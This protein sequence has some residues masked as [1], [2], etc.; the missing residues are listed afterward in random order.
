MYYNILD[1]TRR[2]I[3][4]LFQELKSHFYLAG[5]TAL[6]L[7]IGH[8]DSYDFDF[9]TENDIDTKKLFT[10][11]EVICKNISLLKVHEERNTLNLILDNKIQVSFMTFPYKL[12]TPCI[13][14]E[15]VHIASIPDI[16]CM[17]LNAITGRAE[18]KDY[19][20]LYY[21]LQ[22]YT[23]PQILQYAQK[24]FLRIDE[25][26]FLKSLVYFDDL[27]E[28]DPIL[29]KDGKD[30]SLDELKTYFIKLVKKYK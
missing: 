29:Y 1:T 27:I 20:D 17:K 30:I 5:G 26:L 11:L 2:S 13:M 9:F 4:P 25:N 3:L 6:A 15:Y 12:I 18:L 23:L 14:E 21:I 8:R 19:V 7:Q 10:D 16:A 28:S 24:K 22:E